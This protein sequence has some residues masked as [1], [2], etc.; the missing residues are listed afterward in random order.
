MRILVPPQ[1]FGIPFDFDRHP[2]SATF[3]FDQ[4]ANCQLY[5]YAL[6]W[7]FDKFVPPY[8]SSE[9]WE[10]ELHT[11]VVTQLEPLDLVL[12]HD[13]PNAWGAHVAVYIGENH[14][15]H[16]SHKNGVPRIETMEQML[17]EPKYPF[18]IGA[19]RALRARG[20]KLVA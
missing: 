20:E 5:A 1:F 10:D 7:H 17:A 12:L 8:R 4:G 14:V 13:T 3:D 19:K 15:V 6:L 9:L 11:S 16:L 18:L 2:Q